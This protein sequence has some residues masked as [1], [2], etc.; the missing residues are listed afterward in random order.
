MAKAIKHTV[1]IVLGLLV[2]FTACQTDEW[3]TFQEKEAP[4]GYVNIHFETEIPAMPVVTTR[5]VDPDGKGV[6]NMQLFCFDS[7]GLFITTTPATITSHGEES[8]EFTATIPDNTRRIH[9]IAN[10][11]MTDFQEDEFRNKSEADVIALLEGSSGMMIYWARF[12]CDANNEESIDQQ[13]AKN[14]NI[15]MIRNQAKITIDNP[16]GNGY[17]VVTG[18]T[19]YNT[20]AFGTVA[21]Y[22]PTK[23]WVWSSNADVEPFVTLPANDAKL[24]DIQ[25]VQD[26]S[27]NPEL[28]VFECENSSEDP[29]SV[30]IRGYLPGESEELY[31]RVMLIKENGEQEL[32]RRNHHYTF[33]IAGALS[34]GQPTFEAA[35]TAAATNNVWLSISDEVESVEDNNYILAVNQTSVVYNDERAGKTAELKYTLSGKNGTVITEADKPV[36]TWLDGNTVAANTITEAFT[37]NSNGE[38]EGKIIINLLPMNNNQKLE[39]TLLVKKDRLQ[40]KIKVIMVKKQNF[41]P[42]WASTEIYGNMDDGGAHATIM[43]TIPED[44]PTELFPLRVLL[45][46]EALDVRHESGMVLPLV[47]EGEEGYGT[48]M[49]EW[50]YKYVYTVTEPGVQRV[51]F[52][53]ILNEEDGATKDISIEAEHFNTMHR[54]FTFA[55]SSQ[56]SI[57]V[58]GLGEY[59]G[60]EGGGDFA[61]DE[62]ILYRLV[63]QKKGA[64]VQFDMLLKDGVT[65]INAGDKDEFLLYSQYLDHIKDGEEPDGVTFDCTFYEVD[66]SEWGSGGRVY[67]FKP[68]DAGNPE[69][70]GRYSIY[71]KTNVARSAE[72]VRMASNQHGSPSGLPSNNGAEYTGN[73][74]RSVTFELANYHPFRFAARVDDIGTD[75]SGNAEEEETPL[76]WTYEPEQEV[77]ISFDV[78]SF[79]GSDGKS[80]DPFGEEFEIYIDA[81]MLEIDD[82]R[83]KEFNL[84]KNKLKADP[85]T[86]GRFIYTVEANREDERRYGVGEALQKDD[87]AGAGSQEGERKKLP[88]KTKSAVSAGDIVVSSNNRQ[89]VFF[90]KTFKVTNESITGTIRYTANEETKP[91]PKGA[92]VSFEREVN[93]SRIGVMTI[94][95]DGRYELRLRKE[96]NFDWYIDNVELHY[97]VN[98]EVYHTMTKLDELFSN[99]D[100]VLTAATN[101]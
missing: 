44:C 99:R 13:L 21:P 74:Y 64:L 61:D 78:T 39:G 94:R 58:V 55:G 49:P 30:I 60:A 88:F 95:E 54:V 23:G 67:M 71:M 76:T 62:K 85:S 59:N 77:D 43:F 16:T 19:A 66:K 80:V 75:A 42:A 90:E 70:T 3:T 22:H 47:R 15:I 11:N 93:G 69:E 1:L 7:Y 34:Y 81:P 53:N 10:Q 84:D 82:A 32:I 52:R 83:L 86:E 92:F 14:P 5:S 45:A 72:V 41:T 100:L 24:S 17:L 35:L 4:E 8:G 73:T 97:T 37:I 48:E 18:F 89:V 63:P 29:V 31:Y 33:H 27:L 91:V 36:V 46:V 26:I 68:I 28:Y 25:D 6:N 98:G 50:K 38:G 20:N 40:R 101:E 79:T 65:A 56:K 96:Y 51:Y 87:A 9:F 57:T 2:S 12:A